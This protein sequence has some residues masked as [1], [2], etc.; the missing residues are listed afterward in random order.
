M[1]FRKSTSTVLV[2]L[3]LVSAHSLAH[4]RQCNDFNGLKTEGGVVRYAAEYDPKRDNAIPQLAGMSDWQSLPR[5]CR[6]VSTTGVE[7]HSNITVELWMPEG[8]AWNGKFLGTG[9]GGFAGAIRYEQLVGGLKHGYAV[10]NTDMGTFPASSVGYAAGLGYPQMIKDW[11]YRATHEMTVLSLALVSQYYGRRPLRSYFSGCSTGGHQAL[12][13]AQR[14]PNDY[15]AIIAGAPGHNR[16]HLHQM[17]L[18]TFL[19]GH[20]TKE[21]FIPIEKAQ[22][23]TSAILSRCAGKDGGAPDDKY[24]MDPTACSWSPKELLCKPEAQDRGNCLT[25]G[26]VNTLEKIYRGGL[27]PKSN[28]LFYP[29]WVK[30]SEKA[31]LA[32]FG[33]ENSVDLAPALTVLSLTQWAFGPSYS[34]REFDFDR[35]IARM[36]AKLGPDINA[37]S[38]DLSAFSR[39]GGKLILFH[40]W[41]DA[42]VSPLDTI[43]YF[44][45]LSASNPSRDN[46]VRLFMA[47]GMGHCSA[48]VG[49][50]N[51]FGQ[52]NFPRPDHNPENDLLDALDAWATNGRA[53]NEIIARRYEAN[54]V[55]A[56]R[57]LCAF[58]MQALYKNGSP[59]EAA[60]FACAV[61]SPPKFEEPA[62]R[63]Q[64]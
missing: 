40:G 61:A 2:F 27:D 46:F 10:A 50:A 9:N 1:H 57:P 53:P 24:L 14:Y 33:A 11:G 47:P 16:T 19:D 58:P 63:Y 31:F 17:F 28:E 38:S 34:A 18:Q 15:D 29:G 3:A 8:V 52:M 4:A 54:E 48:D 45:R 41:A 30:G 36:D 22:L 51:D 25:Q 12:S 32:R 5:F 7:R 26:Q 39:R 56:S 49:G 43:V 44:E 60:S 21:S 64:R 6:I 37:M 62:S 55:T 42:T 20:A 23:I 13:E 35:D 59:A